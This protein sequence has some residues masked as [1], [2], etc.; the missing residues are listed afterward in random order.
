MSHALLRKLDRVYRPRRP[1]P[2]GKALRGVVECLRAEVEEPGREA[3]PDGAPS[4]LGPTASGQDWFAVKVVF[5]VDPLVEATCPA[6]VVTGLGPPASLE[7]QLAG[8]AQPAN[9]P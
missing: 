1:D 2:V 6:R 5:P 7:V 4:A 3:I 8:P 9:G